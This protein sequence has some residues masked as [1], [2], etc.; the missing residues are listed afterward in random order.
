MHNVGVFV[1][2]CV[3][4]NTFSWFFQDKP[5]LQHYLYIY[6]NTVFSWKILILNIPKNMV[7]YWHCLRFKE[8]SSDMNNSEWIIDNWI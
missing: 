3:A 7:L 4:K 6:D 5:G 1:T 2:C 8:N